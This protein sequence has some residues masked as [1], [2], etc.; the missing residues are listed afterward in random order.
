[1]LII[2]TSTCSLTHLISLTI[3]TTYPYQQL[4]VLSALGNDVVFCSSGWNALFF[5]AMGGS[6]RIVRLLISSK[7]NIHQK[8]MRYNVSDFADA[9]SSLFLVTR[10]R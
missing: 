2:L 4:H 5:A 3:P 6:E 9:S 8:A 10:M 1:M 7:A